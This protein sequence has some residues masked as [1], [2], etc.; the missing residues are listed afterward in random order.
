MMVFAMVGE[1]LQ[2]VGGDCPDGFIVMNSLRP[3]DLDAPYYVAQED[4][5]W[6]VNQ[7]AKQASEGIIENAWRAEQMPL[8]MEAVTAFQMGEEDISGTEQLW[9]DYWIALRKWTNTN[10]DFPDTS[11]RPIAPS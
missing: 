9:K 8:A 5:E 10:P 1:N 2:Q 3:D 6:A 11:K 4:G 7:E